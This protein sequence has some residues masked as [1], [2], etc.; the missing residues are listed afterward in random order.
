MPPIFSPLRDIHQFPAPFCAKNTDFFSYSIAGNSRNFILFGSSVGH[1]HLT[2]FP[3]P[4]CAVV[5]KQALFFSFLFFAV[6]RMLHIRETVAAL[7]L[8][9][10]L[11]PPQL[12]SAVGGGG[13]RGGNTLCHAKNNKKIPFWNIYTFPSFLTSSLGEIIFI[14][15]AFRSSKYPA[16]TPPAFSRSIDLQKLCRH[17]RYL[18]GD[19]KKHLTTFPDGSP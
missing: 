11:F 19:A 6:F 5:C 3:R 18:C 2:S 7:D 13:E 14:L 4:A 8:A 9:L 17:Q 10:I 12:C 15:F 16:P 1:S